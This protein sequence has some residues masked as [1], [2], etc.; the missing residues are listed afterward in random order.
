MKTRSTPASLSLKGQVTKDTT[1]KWSI[2]LV[3][4]VYIICSWI[5]FNNRLFNG[6]FRFLLVWFCSLF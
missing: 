6:Q 4:I 3:F 1:V 5:F 2:E